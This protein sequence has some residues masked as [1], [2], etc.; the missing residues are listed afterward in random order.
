MNKGLFSTLFLTTI[1]TLHG[2]GQKILFEAK[3]PERVFVG[4]QFRLTYTLNDEGRDF[5]VPQSF[6]GF[7]IVYGPSTSSSYTSSVVGGKTVTEVSTSYTFLLE[8]VKEGTFRIPKATITV[9]GR[10]IQS[11][12]LKIE[13]TSKSKKD[14]KENEDQEDNSQSKPAYSQISDKDAFIQTLVSKSQVSQQ[15]AF[16]V[17]YKL[18]TK[19]AVQEIGRTRLPDFDGFQVD[20]L[21]VP[22]E[23]YRTETFNGQTY[24]TATIRKLLLT[25]E[26]KG[27]LEIP[28]STIALAFQIPTGIKTIFGQQMAVVTKYV[29]TQPASIKVNAI[30]TP[31]PVDFSNVAGNFT[32]SSSISTTRAKVNNPVLIRI[33]ISGNGNVTRIPVPELQFPDEFDSK[34]PQISQNVDVTEDGIQGTKTIEYVF[35]PRQTGDYKIPSASIPYFDTTSKSYKT[36]SIPEYNLK[37]NK[38]IDKNSKEIL[39]QIHSPQSSEM[40]L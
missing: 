25:P 8:S 10:T 23:P 20:Y 12:N 28:T 38:D 1:F 40:I 13:S 30:P 5:K 31:T 21:N 9:D 33:V 34:K 2:F 17:T 39:V 6:D 36:L 24:Y 11:N 29:T 3:A 26:Q 35:I 14:G 22:G 37:V 16:V 18:Y 32:I 4:E 15:E 19:L 27:T 7:E